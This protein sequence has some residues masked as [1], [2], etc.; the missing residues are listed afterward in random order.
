VTYVG[1]ENAEHLINALLCIY[2]FTTDFGG[3]VYS[4]MNL[5]WDYKNRTCDISMTDYIANVLSKFQ[6]ENPK[7]QQDTASAY[8]TPVCSTKTQY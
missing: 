3:T 8:V 1:K 4:G 2:K 7:N 6:L 5:K